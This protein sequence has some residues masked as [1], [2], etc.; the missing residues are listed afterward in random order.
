LPSLFERFTVKYPKTVF[1]RDHALGCKRS[2]NLE[3]EIAVCETFA[4]TFEIAAENRETHGKSARVGRPRC[5]I[6][7]IM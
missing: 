3:I 1:L 5:S 6:K 7:S 4:R 2:I